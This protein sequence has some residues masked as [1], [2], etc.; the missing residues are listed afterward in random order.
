M[1]EF[2]PKCSNLL[3]KKIIDGKFYMYCKCGYKKQIN[4]NNLNFEKNFMK[5]EK[6]DDYKENLVIISG[7]EKILIHPKIQK[8]CPKCG[9]QEAVYW[10]EQILRADEPITTFFRCLRCK[11]VWREY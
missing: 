8:T 6:K 5:K 2:C 7:K 4:P 1:V 10:Q 9:F 11:K 3:R